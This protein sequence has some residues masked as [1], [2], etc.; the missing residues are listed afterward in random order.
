[1]AAEAGRDEP[2]G[3]VNEGEDFWWRSGRYQEDIRKDHGVL[4]A[5]PVLVGE[6]EDALDGR[7]TVDRG[8]FLREHRHLKEQDDEPVKKVGK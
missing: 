1:M 3:C 4:Q 8:V 6:L 2:E 7:A 5:L